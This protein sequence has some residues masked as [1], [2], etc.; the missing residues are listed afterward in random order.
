MNLIRWFRHLLCR[1]VVW[2]APDLA[3]YDRPDRV[4]RMRCKECGYLVDETAGVIRQC[5]ELQLSERAEK[6]TWP[7]ITTRR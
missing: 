5:H 6:T 1:D 2:I 3:I 4:Y 7:T